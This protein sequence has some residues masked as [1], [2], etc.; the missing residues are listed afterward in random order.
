VSGSDRRLDT[1]AL[2]VAE[3]PRAFTGFLLPRDVRRSA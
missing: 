2:T 3:P 1:E